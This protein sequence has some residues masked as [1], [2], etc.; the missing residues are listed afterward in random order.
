M[1]KIAIIALLTLLARG[2][3][4]AQILLDGEWSPQYRED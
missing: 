3:S 2:T 4:S 1:L